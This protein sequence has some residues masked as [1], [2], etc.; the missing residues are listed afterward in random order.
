MGTKKVKYNESGIQ[1]LPNN[2][3]VLYQIKTEAGNINY[4]GIAQRGR[5]QDRIREHI[6]KIPGATVNVEQFNRIDDARKKE[7]KVIKRNKPKYNDQGK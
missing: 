3:P 1:D 5:V 7:T 6:G 4:A 2:K